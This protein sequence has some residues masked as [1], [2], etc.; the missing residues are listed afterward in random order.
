MVPR[1]FSKAGYTAGPPNLPPSS[2]EGLPRL[3]CQE[4][5]PLSSASNHRT[6]GDPHPLFQPHS[7]LAQADTPRNRGTRRSIS[8][9]PSRAY[10]LPPRL[11]L[12]AHPDLPQSP[13]DPPSRAPALMGLLE[14]REWLRGPQRAP[15][16][17][18]E[19]GPPFS[20]SVGGAPGFRRRRQMHCLPCPLN[21]AAGRPSARKRPRD[22][23]GA[24]PLRPRV[25]RRKVAAAAAALPPPSRVPLGSLPGPSRL[26]AGEESG[27]PGS[28]AARA[29]RAGGGNAGGRRARARARPGAVAGRAPS[30]S[31]AVL[32]R[33]RIAFK[34]SPSPP[35]GRAGG[36]RGAGRA[37]RH[38]PPEPVR[39]HFLS[40]V[41]QFG[42]VPNSNPN[43]LSPCPD[44]AVPQTQPNFPVWARDSGSSLFFQRKFS[45]GV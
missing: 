8:P 34:T 41:P 1:A 20:R 7:H 17:R 16:D 11:Q 30:H 31:L 22:L 25:G 38:V 14:R 6:L 45:L 12:L 2:M 5:E 26:T 9:T 29:R 36:G 3:K 23:P 42:P 39:P 27:A 44:S 40:P 43:F 21:L 19:S 24:P 28:A 15:V 4:L 13:C 35:R 10:A 32:P 33:G 18:V 37:R